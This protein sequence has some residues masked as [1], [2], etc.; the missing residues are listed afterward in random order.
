MAGPRFQGEL[1]E[2]TTSSSPRFGGGELVESDAPISEPVAGE[3]K[4]KTLRERGTQLLESV[5]SK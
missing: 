3:P 2:D 1:V 5:V 4:T